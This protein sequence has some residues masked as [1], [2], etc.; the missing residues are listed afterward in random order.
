MPGVSGMPGLALRNR[1]GG[2]SEFSKKKNF[3]LS[4][5]TESFANAK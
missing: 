4:E 1:Y 2:F 5:V 3:F